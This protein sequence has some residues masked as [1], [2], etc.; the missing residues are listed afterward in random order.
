MIEQK[1]INFMQEELKRTPIEFHRYMYDKILWH[2]R[3]VG[4]VGPRGVGKSTMVK[5]FLLANNKNSDWLYVSADHTYFNTHSLNELAYE[6]IK[7]GGKHLI[8]DE[9][10][11]LQNWSQALKEIYDSH[12]NFQVIYT[13]SSI[14]DIKKGMV[15]LS[16]RTLLF[17]MQGMSFREYL[18][19]YH[20]IDLPVLNLTDILSQKW[21]MPLEFH[22]LPLF[23]RYLREGYY[24]FS[25][26]PGYDI[27][28]Q[29][30]ISQTLEVD[31]PAFAGLNLS[32]TRKL[33]K[34]LSIISSSAPY[35]PSVLNLA[36]ELKI[37]KNDVS[38]YL[39]YLEKAGMLSQVRD[40][41]GGMRGLGKVEKVFV[42]NTNLMFA[43]ITG[44]PE[45]GTQRE[46][47]FYNQMRINNDVM[48]SKHA[49]FRIEEFVFEVGGKN[50]GRK[51]IIDERNGIV[52]KDDI[53]FGQKGIIPLWH[54]GLNY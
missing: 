36:S 32:T 10:H 13:G 21:E 18:K 1:L 37:S 47:F 29:Q 40:D 41:T 33:K 19:L 22:P 12:S 46:T 28:L 27:R 34:L 15:D 20:D 24:P 53:E 39:L 44:E 3:L 35:K 11:K 17:E 6:F 38:E 16:R 43:L 48:T 45:Q 2:D 26:L 5:Q 23:R 50:K 9:I 7:E 14:L 54:F 8:V 31:I 49:D 4:I 52:V 25:H 42:D 30:V 51:Q